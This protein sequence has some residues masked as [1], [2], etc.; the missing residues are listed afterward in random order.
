MIFDFANLDGQ[1]VESEHFY[2]LNGLIS[3]ALQTQELIRDSK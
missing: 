1:G 3:L 2:G